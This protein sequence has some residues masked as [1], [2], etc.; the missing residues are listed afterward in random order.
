[1]GIPDYTPTWVSGE[2]NKQ[3]RVSHWI[4][5]GAIVYT[6]ISFG[7]NDLVT[8]SVLTLV[9]VLVILLNIRSVPG[10]RHLFHLWLFSVFCLLVLVVAAFLQSIR[11]DN[12]PFEH[13]IWK[14]VRDNVGPVAGAISVAPE[15]TRASLV[16]FAPLLGFILSLTLFQ[17]LPHALVMLKRLSYFS[18]SIALYGIAQHL[19]FPTQLG[20]GE[21]QFYLDNLTAFFVNR[22]AAGT[23]FGVGATLTLALPFYYLRSIDPAKLG[24]KVL[25]PSDDSTHI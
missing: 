5:L 1:M 15:Q 23:F 8:E 3:L 6:A 24:D 21:K 25:E 7:G 4:Y 22:N 2:T 10:N 14:I 20:L 12:N 16:E 9:L 19:L 11:L 18:A 17:K 13:P